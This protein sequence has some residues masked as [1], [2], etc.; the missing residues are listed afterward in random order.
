MIVSNE[1]AREL[2]SGEISLKF[3]EEFCAQKTPEMIELIEQVD[4][5]K[6]EFLI[7][8]IANPSGRALVEAGS[9]CVRKNSQEN[10]NTDINRNFLPWWSHGEASSAAE[11]Y[12]G[13]S[14]LSTFEARVIDNLASNPS[15]GKPSVYLD[16]HSGAR[17]IMTP[18]AFIN[19]K[20]NEYDKQ[21]KILNII[22][23]TF[24][25]D[26]QIGPNSVTIGY[27]GA[28]SALDSMFLNRKI[29]YSMLWET[30]VGAPIVGNWGTLE[31]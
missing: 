29:K 2:I 21:F 12:R 11:V 7:I 20:S 30:Y 26:C 1:H 16:L 18:W 13:T 19:G 6:L 4:Q 8:P 31:K 24:C 14:P 3:I 27:A 28:G 17:T 22:K 15:L 5:G 25:E 9:F 10:G 23:D